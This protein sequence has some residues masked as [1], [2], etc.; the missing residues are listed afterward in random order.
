[1]T[2]RE[3]FLQAAQLV[4]SGAHTYPCTAVFSLEGVNWHQPE[5]LTRRFILTM[6]PG[7]SGFVY[8]VAASSAYLRKTVGDL[9]RHSVL[10]LCFM[11]AMEEG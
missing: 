4:H 7:S 8:P 11:A 1:M 10:A 9:R 2:P 6:A 5:S 3:I